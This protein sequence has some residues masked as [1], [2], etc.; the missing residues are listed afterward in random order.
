MREKRPLEQYVIPIDS[1]VKKL[2]LMFVSHYPTYS[3]AARAVGLNRDTI[4]RYLEGNSAVAAYAFQRIAH[5]LL[6]KHSRADLQDVLGEEGVD[7]M[8]AAAVKK[9]GAATDHMS[10]AITPP[11]RD[12]LEA[13]ARLFVNR[14]AAAR[15]LRINPRTFAAYFKATIGS[16]PRDRFWRA[17]EILKERGWKQGPLFAKHGA[18]SWD[19]LL[20]VARKQAPMSRLGDEDLQTALID[21]IRSGDL[22]IKTGD[23]PLFNACRRR[24]GNL[25]AALRVAMSA[26]VKRITEQIDR[27]IDAGD[28]RGARQALDELGEATR[29]YM[30][31]A[32]S[33]ARIPTLGSTYDWQAEVRE[34]LAAKERAEERIRGEEAKSVIGGAEHGGEAA[35]AN[36]LYRHLLEAVEGGTLEALLSERSVVRG[37]RH[38]FGGVGRALAR[39]LSAAAAA[40]ESRVRSAV[41][42]GDLEEAVQEV[43]K[44]EG[45]L[46]DYVRWCRGP[47]R[48]VGERIVWRR[49]VDKYIELRNRLKSQILEV[50]HL[51]RLDT[52]EELRVRFHHLKGYRTYVPEHDYR[53]GELVFHPIYGFG[54]VLS[55]EGP[56]R[57]AVAFQPSKER[58][59]LV[60]NL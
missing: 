40:V 43:A 35:R 32:K 29:H 41:E 4:A 44:L 13:Y 34:Y 31:R 46:R 17:V 11:V 53:V 24:Y 7:G 28:L 21:H 1:R 12:I 57:M 49:E 47:A 33:A 58:V 19:Q 25:T 9:N 37:L 3:D 22:K 56:T 26:W 48:K 14:A 2:L 60:R 16:F 30:A 18:K 50:R 45:Y 27:C 51:Y 6:K 15:A 5:L 52:E 20:V 54:R 10:Y 36:E 8:L 59:T 38:A 55:H 23:R 39:A 42:R